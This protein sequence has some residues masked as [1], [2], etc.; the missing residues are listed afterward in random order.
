MDHFL[1]M[2]PIRS[3]HTA[4][5]HHTVPRP[6]T[7]FLPYDTWLQFLGLLLSLALC[8]LGQGCVMCA[9]EAS[10]EL[11]LCT[12]SL[13]LSRS[14]TPSHPILPVLQPSFHIC[15]STPGSSIPHLTLCFPEPS[16]HL[17][18]P[19]CPVLCSSTFSLETSLPSQ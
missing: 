5:A 16:S 7:T 10:T 1:S 19:F 12:Q 9:T 17:H 11:G 2:R 4:A 15:L 14:P 6:P 3:S 13:V 18:P 8:P